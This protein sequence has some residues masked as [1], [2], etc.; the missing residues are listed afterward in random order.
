MKKR[1]RP[2]LMRMDLDWDTNVLEDM[3]LERENIEVGSP[4][5]KDKTT[6]VAY[7]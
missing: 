3:G 2:H 5:P 4:T 6:L 7:Q 1:Q